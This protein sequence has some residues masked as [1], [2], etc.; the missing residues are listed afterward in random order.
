MKLYLVYCLCTM[1]TILPSTHTVVFS[2]TFYANLQKSDNTTYITTTMNALEINSQ[3]NKQ[4][5]NSFLNNAS[6]NTLFNTTIIEYFTNYHHELFIQQLCT[7]INWIV[8]PKASFLLTLLQK[9]SG[10]RYYRINYDIFFSKIVQYH[11]LSNFFLEATLKEIIKLLPQLLSDTD[12][13]GNTLLSYLASYNMLNS[14][15]L[16]APHMTADNIIKK[17]NYGKNAI[18]ATNNL[19]IQQI[20][21]HYIDPQK[22]LPHFILKKNTLLQDPPD[23]I[24]IS[25]ASLD[26]IS[27]D[28]CIYALKNHILYVDNYKDITQAYYNTAIHLPL[29]FAFITIYGTEEPINLELFTTALQHGFKVSQS[30]IIKNKT[31][32]GLDFARTQG[33]APQ[34]ITLLENAFH[35]EIIDTLQTSL[36]TL[37]AL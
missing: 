24:Q 18:D 3:N 10:I 11:H 12:S 22:P 20:I 25:N 19:L 30:S 36:A 21:Q 26:K 23:W 34:L 27:A 16:L 32:N 15:I 17:N 6:A 35:Q 9:Q 7:T 29:F 37:T 33:V 4:C 2:D 5:I 1:C 14:I 31:V 8:T 28:T 13:D